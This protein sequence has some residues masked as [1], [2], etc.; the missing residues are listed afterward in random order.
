MRKLMAMGFAVVLIGNTP[1]PPAPIWQTLNEGD[2]PEQV[3][4]KLGAIVGIRSTKPKANSVSVKYEGE[5]IPIYGT[6]F[7]VIPQFERASLN[8]VL[9]ASRGLCVDAARSVADDMLRALS[10]KYPE[11]M[12]PDDDVGERAVLRAMRRATQAEPAEVSHIRM[13][14]QTAMIFY[15][16]VTRKDTPPTGFATGRTADAA[17]AF[18]WGEYERFVSECPAHGSYRVQLA[19]V[20][21]SRPAFENIRAQNEAEM[22]DEER[23]AADSL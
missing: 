1:E 7:K 5:G 15:Q 23:K 8:Q 10:A 4:M 14:Q 12:V 19:V 3:A 22:I 2:T 18:L 6:A 11:A 9:L 20:Y 13:N 17:R 21:M 16:R